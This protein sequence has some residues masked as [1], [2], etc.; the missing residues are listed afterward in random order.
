M[1]AIN[2]VVGDFLLLLASVLTAYGAMW[3]IRKA[4]QLMLRS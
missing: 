1:P 4:L 2:I 3:A